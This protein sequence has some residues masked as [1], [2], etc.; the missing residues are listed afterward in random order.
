MT[1]DD[2]ETSEEVQRLWELY[3]NWCFQHHIPAK[4]DGFTIWF[5]EQYA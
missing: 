1:L 2:I 3:V 5:E 4:A